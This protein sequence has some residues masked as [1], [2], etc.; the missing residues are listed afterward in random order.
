M[1][2]EMSAKGNFG[3]RC[4]EIITLQRE[5]VGDRGSSR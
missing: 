1:R 3:A 2:T 5:T 4:H